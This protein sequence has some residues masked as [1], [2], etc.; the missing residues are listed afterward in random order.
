M[1]ICHFPLQDVALVHKCS[2]DDT[3][4]VT[5]YFKPSWVMEVNAHCW[6]SFFIKFVC[7]SLW[8]QDMQTKSKVNFYSTRICKPID[9]WD[10]AV[11]LELGLVV[12]SYSPNS[13]LVT[14][15]MPTTSTGL[16]QNL[17]DIIM[18]CGAIVARGSETAVVIFFISLSTGN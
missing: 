5:Q 15:L 11:V 17:H 13:N 6:S 14:W 7:R 10:S 8:S 2:W 9:K 18:V 4:L 12:P 16:T 1:R 3:N